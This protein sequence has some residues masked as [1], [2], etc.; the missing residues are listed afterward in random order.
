M[1]ETLI[2]PA[3][4][5]DW[6]IASMRMATPLLFAALGGIISERAGIL[7]IGIEGMMLTGAL[8][9]TVGSFF[10]GG[11][12]MGTL[13]GGISGALVAL[14]LAYMAVTLKANQTVVG[15]AINLFSLGVTGFFM[16]VIFQVTDRPVPV[17]AFGFAPVP[18]LHQIPVV[19][20]IL[21]GH[22]ALV[23][24]AFLLVPVVWFFVFKTA[25]G[26]NLRA[27]GEYP[28]AAETM[29]I[30][31]NRIR[32][33]AT[34]VGGFLA[35][36]G[37]AYISLGQMNTFMDNMVA[38]RGFIALGA[39]IFG[40]W[41]PF[42]VM[43]ATMLFGAAD[44]LQMRFQ[45]LGFAVPYHLVLM[46]PYLLTMVTLIGFGRAARPPAAIGVP[47]IKEIK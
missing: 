43:G 20:G 2:S 44:A 27:V 24:L 30:R 28:M 8:F 39:I 6:M 7:N 34:L 25:R 29:G 35:G 21:F 16:R 4:L 31:V 46:L 1:I 22:K 23:Y 40:K 18:F 19:G 10:L 45:A 14:I 37:G 47:Y 41:N 3:F 15:A 38:G 17:P 13:V 26:L 9:A 11:P 36:V 12:W 32:Y 33:A 42:G 5:S